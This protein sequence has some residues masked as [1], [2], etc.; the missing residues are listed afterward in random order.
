M[1]SA[2]TPLI[3]SFIGDERFIRSVF[4]ATN[5]PLDS[6]DS[7]KELDELRCLVHAQDVKINQLETAFEL[8]RLA[9]A[10]MRERCERIENQ[11]ACML[12]SQLNTDA[13]LEHLMSD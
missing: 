12:Q 13:L 9:N 2:C 1:K 4:N 7:A 11:N 3:Q 8:E 10:I 5:A 6:G